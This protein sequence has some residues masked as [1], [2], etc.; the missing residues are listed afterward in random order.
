MFQIFLNRVKTLEKLTPGVLPFIQDHRNRHESIG[1]LRLPVSEPQLPWAY[2]A[3]FP[4]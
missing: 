4:R 2:L 1:H 3:P